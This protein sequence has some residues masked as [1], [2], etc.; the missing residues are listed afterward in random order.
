MAEYIQY[1]KNIADSLLA[2]GQPIP[3]KD[4]VL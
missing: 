4:V 2:I 3:D 1:V